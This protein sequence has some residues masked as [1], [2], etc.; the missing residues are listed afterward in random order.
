[1]D[2]VKSRRNSQKMAYILVILEEDP[3]RKRFPKK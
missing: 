1:M 2:T 3:A